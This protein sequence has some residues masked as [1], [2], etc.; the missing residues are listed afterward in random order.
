LLLALRHPA[1]L[2]DQ[3]VLAHRFAP[4]LL[5]VSVGRL[6]GI[7]AGVAAGRGGREPREVV[8]PALRVRLG[9]RRAGQVAVHEPERRS[10]SARDEFDLDRARPGRKE[11]RPAATELP[12]PRVDEAAERVDLEDDAARDAAGGH[13]DPQGAARPQVERDRPTPPAM[14]L[15]G[16]DEVRPH[17]LRARLALALPLAR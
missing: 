5:A 4:F 14:C 10:F 3:Y 17:R 16:I 13:L 15:D 6:P 2:V 9:R 1:A 12:A 7:G 8:L 11:L